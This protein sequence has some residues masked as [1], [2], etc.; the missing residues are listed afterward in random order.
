M[1]KLQYSRLNGLNKEQIEELVNGLKDRQRLLGIET[2][3]GIELYIGDLHIGSMLVETQA[4]SYVKVTL[5]V[6]YST[7]IEVPYYTDLVHLN[8]Y[9]NNKVTVRFNYESEYWQS[10]KLE[11]A[12]KSKSVDLDIEFNDQ[13]KFMLDEVN[14]RHSFGYIS[15]CIRFKGIGSGLNLVT[16]DA[17]LRD[18]KEISENCFMDFQ[19]SS[20]IIIRPEQFRELIHHMIDSFGEDAET[21]IYVNTSKRAKE[22]KI[23]M[24]E[25]LYKEYED[26]IME[27]NGLFGSL[28]DIVIDKDLLQISNYGG[29][30]TALKRDRW[31]VDFLKRCNILGEQVLV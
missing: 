13:L 23:N 12:V 21:L 25:L 31:F 20:R 7:E 22:G 16:T 2:D 19:V 28:I 4:I 11:V 24:K 14:L 6:A 9:C 30:S 17:V 5:D 15:K 8:L 3:N 10:K 1:I 26:I 29:Y 27:I 18:T